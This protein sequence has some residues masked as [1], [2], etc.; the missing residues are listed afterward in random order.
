MRP[1]T[2]AKFWM[3]KGYGPTNYIHETQDS[4]EA[5][6]ERLAAANPGQPFVVLEAI[7]AHRC[8]TVQRFEMREN[9]AST[10]SDEEIAF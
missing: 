7:A 9:Y 8:I 3:V 5:E 4:A 6:A 1:Y 2:P 10:V